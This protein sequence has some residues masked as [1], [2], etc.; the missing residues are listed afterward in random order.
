MEPERIRLVKPGFE[1]VCVLV[2][3]IALQEFLCWNL[4]D[5]FNVVIVLTRL[6]IR[7]IGHF[8]QLHESNT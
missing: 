5:W 6:A 2:S 4:E 1:A 7:V 8:Q 3:M